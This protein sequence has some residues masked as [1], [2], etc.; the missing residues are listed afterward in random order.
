M[1]ALIG[2]AGFFL[3]K[4][5]AGY[6]YVGLALSV[7]SERKRFDEEQDAIVVTITLKKSGSGMIRL[8]DGQVQFSPVDGSS[9][10]SSQ[11]SWQRGVLFL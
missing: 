2:A 9:L 6:F 11:K 8:H 1:L 7:A 3:Y 5:F 4:I 10:K